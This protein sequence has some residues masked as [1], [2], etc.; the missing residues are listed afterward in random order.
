MQIPHGLAW[1]RT[2]VLMMRIQHSDLKHTTWIQIMKT[3]QMIFY[4]L[5]MTD[6]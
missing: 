4:H 1:D 5:K 6:F 3:T 2:K